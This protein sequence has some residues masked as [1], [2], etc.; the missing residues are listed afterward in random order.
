MDGTCALWQKTGNQRKGG[1]M[2]GLNRIKFS[3]IIRNVQLIINYL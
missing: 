2:Y 3:G 1:L